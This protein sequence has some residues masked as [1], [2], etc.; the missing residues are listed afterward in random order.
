[1]VSKRSKPSKQLAASGIKV[2]SQNRK[3]RH[4][5]DI[6]QTF[7]AGIELK[8]SEIKSV[9]LGKAQLRDSFVRIDNN[10]AW[11]F[12]AHIPPYDFAHGF[13]SHDPDR[14]KKLLLHRDEIEELAVRTKLQSLTIIPLAIYLKNGRAKI[15]IA[16]AKGRKSYDKRAAIAQ[17]DSQ[18]DTERELANARRRS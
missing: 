3:A 6:S 4:D 2:V 12:Q 18:R 15:E 9:R 17:R 1:M 13:G 11:L 16:L 14:P 5:Y 7:E 8:G 10:E